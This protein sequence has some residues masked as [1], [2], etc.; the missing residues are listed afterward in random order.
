[1]EILWVNL[2]E[3]PSWEVQVY[4][5]IGAVWVPFISF[6]ACYSR[7]GMHMEAVDLQVTCWRLS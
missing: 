4:M 6:V 5:H 2:G 1:M 3:Q 7:R